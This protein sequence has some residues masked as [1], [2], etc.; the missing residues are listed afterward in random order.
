MKHDGIVNFI[1]VLVQFY[2]GLISMQLAVLFMGYGREVFLEDFAH[3]IN[4]FY[5]LY[6]ESDAKMNV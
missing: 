4:G 1:I 6:C 5:L 2:V 3:F